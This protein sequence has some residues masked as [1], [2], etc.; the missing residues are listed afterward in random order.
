ML[1]DR[2]D[3]EN[4]KGAGIKGFG[5]TREADFGGFYQKRKKKKI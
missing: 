4:Q 5:W 3:G 1:T 2:I